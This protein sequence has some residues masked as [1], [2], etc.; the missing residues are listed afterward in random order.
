MAKRTSF[1]NILCGIHMPCISARSA[2]GLLRGCRSSR[3]CSVRELIKNDC[4]YESREHPDCETGHHVAEIVHS[5]VHTPHGH[6]EHIDRSKRDNCNPT[7]PWG[8]FFPRDIRKKTA[9]CSRG[10]G[11]SARK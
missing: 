1:M 5:Q 9:K 7:R 10:A 6:Q 2:T 3:S 11:V 8:H 4:T